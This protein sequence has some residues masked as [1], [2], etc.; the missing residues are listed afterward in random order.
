MFTS[1][2]L[3]AILAGTSAAAWTI[4]LKLG[5]ARINPALGAMVISGAAF[6]V[7]A[8]ATLVLKTQGHELVL[9]RDVFWL[10]AIAGIAASGVDIF[11]LLA[12]ERGL[13]VTAS[14]VI[15]ATSIG[16][17][18]LVGFLALQEPLGGVRL[19]ALGL[20]AVGVLL[21]QSHGG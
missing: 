14:L 15:S 2:M 3:F 5:S 13:R 6:V 10:L 20:I 17:T 9:P 7:N 18:L 21:L 11:G 1:A 19:L 4:C 12:Y 16:V 8:A